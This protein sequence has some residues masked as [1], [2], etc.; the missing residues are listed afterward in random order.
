MAELA[1]Q[2]K[3][4]VPLK[5]HNGDVYFYDGGIYHRLSQSDLEAKIY[6]VLRN[7]ID[8]VSSPA[9]IKGIAQFLW[10]DEQLDDT[11]I[12]HPALLCLKNGVLDMSCGRLLEHSPMLFFTSALNVSLS[13]LTPE[14]APAF[15]NFLCQVTGGDPVLRQRRLEVMG[16]L[17]VPGSGVKAKAFISIHGVGNS[18]KSVFDNLI[19]DF[20][21]DNAVSHLDIFRMGDRFS[22]SALVDKRLNISM[23]L[24]SGRFSEAAVGKIKMLTD[25]DGTVVERKYSDPMAYRGG[26]K[27]VFGSNHPIQ[28][29]TPDP[30]FHGRMSV[31]P[32]R[33]AIPK[34]HQNKRLLDQ[35]RQEKSAI[36]KLAL[37]A[38]ALLVQNN[39][40]FAGGALE[41]VQ[42]SHPLA[43]VSLGTLMMDFVGNF[44]KRTAPTVFMA[45]EE[46]RRGFGT[47]YLGKTGNVYPG[48]PA[49]F[50]RL[51]HKLVP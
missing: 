16:Y 23:D 33:Y 36:L 32:F 29:M 6:T 13:D 41:P 3:Q 5:R 14:G 25:G 38:Y 35:L 45:T 24:P 12:E 10:V 46:L 28:L 47:F 7:E 9:L 51:F 34:E 37:N 50:L 15:E 1:I 44:C 39:F 2:M 17:F 31:L 27:L 18:G 19:A 26:R 48:D 8:S 49:S 21:S 42:T 43:V 30:S 22:T 20:F 4:R 40:I 11:P